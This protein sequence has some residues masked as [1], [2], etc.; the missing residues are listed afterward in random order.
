[1][2]GLES[3]TPIV[4]STHVLDDVD[5]ARDRLVLLLEGQVVFDGPVRDLPERM[6]NPSLTVQQC[7]EHA[8]RARSR[9]V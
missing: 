6:D 3:T 7:V 1:M 8:I 4:I 5:E 9:R 2:R